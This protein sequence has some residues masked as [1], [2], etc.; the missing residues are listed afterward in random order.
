MDAVTTPATR[1]IAGAGTPAEAWRLAPALASIP[2]A[3]LDTLVPQRLVVVAPHPDDEVLGCG[4]LLQLLAREGRP[5]VLV[6]V[7]D[8][9]ASHPGSALWPVPRLAAERPRETLAALRVLGMPDLPVHRLG[10]PDGAV[11][12][13]EARLQALLE[14]LVEPGDTVCATW[15]F[16]GHPDH[17]AA[18]R[19]AV[20]AAQARRARCIE[21]PV[22][23]WHWAAPD[24]P[25]LPWHRAVRLAIPPCMVDAKRQALAA[26][27][28]QVEPDPSTGKGAIVPATASA[29][30][31]NDFELFF[32]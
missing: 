24:D 22:W 4:G 2:P 18:G 9:T 15:R 11:A 6:A 30:L 29:R 19:A 8:G 3:S 16:D 26:F 13:H 17:E 25:R 21:M 5:A 14:A 28:S 23:G 32:T 7:T 1:R 31:L 12:R 20:A 27:A 10:L